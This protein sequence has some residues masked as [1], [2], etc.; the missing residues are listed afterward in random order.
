MKISGCRQTTG[1]IEIQDRICEIHGQ[2]AARWPDHNLSLIILA[3]SKPGCDHST[4]LRIL[5]HEWQLEKRD[6]QARQSYC[7]N[8]EARQLRLDDQQVPVAF[9]SEFWQ[10]VEGLFH[11][12]KSG[13]A[14]I[15]EELPSPGDIGATLTL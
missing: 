13:N 7:Y 10:E 8:L 11:L 14:E 4:G 2:I 6:G 12:L 15:F 5:Q 1:P 9:L 3:T